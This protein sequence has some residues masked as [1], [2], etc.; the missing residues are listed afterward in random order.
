MNIIYGNCKLRI[1]AS[2]CSN[3]TWLLALSPIKVLYEYVEVIQRR[4]TSLENL[5]PIELD[6]L[7]V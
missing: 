3:T 7:D 2:S 4:T 6:R 5:K 1:T